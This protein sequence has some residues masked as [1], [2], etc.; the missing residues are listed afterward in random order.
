[1]RAMRSWI[2]QV[3]VLSLAVTFGAGAIAAATSATADTGP[4]PP[5]FEQR[6]PNMVT[7]D[8]LPTVQI[9]NGVVWTTVIVGNTVYAGGQ[10]TNTRP[11]G[12]AAGT[13]LTPRSNLLAFNLTTGN[14]TPRSRRPS[15]VL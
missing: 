5:P 10:F 11:A 14:L 4:Q 13:N 3:V 12:A 8:A 1:M 2:A 6:T 7:A 15:T 9:D